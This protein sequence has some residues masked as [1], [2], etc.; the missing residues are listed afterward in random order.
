MLPTTRSR[1][2][3]TRR[4][5]VGGIFGEPEAQDRDAYVNAGMKSYD[6]DVRSGMGTNPIQDVF[7]ALKRKE[8]GANYDGKNFSVSPG[9]GVGLSDADRRR[10]EGPPTMSRS[11]AGLTPRSGQFDVSDDPRVQQAMVQRALT[12]LEPDN[13]SFDAGGGRMEVGSRRDAEQTKQFGRGLDM[14]R[15]KD[16]FDDA[17]DAK[18]EPREA[19]RKLDLAQKFGPGMARA[20][21][22]V[23]DINSEAEARREFLPHRSNLRDEEFSRRRELTLGPAQTAADGRLA[24]ESVKAQGVVGAAQARRPDTANLAGQAIANMTRSGAFGVDA[25]GRPMPPPPELQQQA[26]D[27]LMEMLSGGGGAG[28]TVPGQGAPQGAAPPMTEGIPPRN[29]QVGATHRFPN[30]KIGKWDGQGWD[31]VG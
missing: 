11:L 12:E 10:Q 20:Q 15:R 8:L 22:E 23:G 25:Q 21:A 18:Y 14:S 19:G 6:A 3:T 1:F 4:K 2:D 29:P 13:F 28:Q 30:G 31:E 27:V 24:A 5:L 16:A 9:Q 26:M 17:Q 7:T